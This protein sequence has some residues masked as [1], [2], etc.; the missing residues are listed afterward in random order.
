MLSLERV[1][2]PLRLPFRHGPEEADSTRDAE[3][4]AAVR[5]KD[6]GRPGCGTRPS[7]I[8][9]D[10]AHPDPT[11][12]PC[13]VLAVPALETSLAFLEQLSPLKA[14]VS[15]PAFRYDSTMASP[16]PGRPL[17]IAA[18]AFY[19]LH[20]P[21][22]CPRRVFLDASGT[23]RAPTSPYDEVLQKLGARH[24]AK[25][26]AT[27]GPHLDLRSLPPDERV[28]RT[29]AAV[30]AG[31]P[32]IFQPR[33]VVEVEL[34]GAQC[35]V[36]GEPDFLIK[37][38]TG[39]VIRDAKMARRVTEADHPEILRQVETYGWLFEQVVGSPPVALEVFSGKSEVVPIASA[40][41][42]QV[43]TALA[44]L[45]QLM[46]AKAEPYSPVGWTKCGPCPFHDHCWPRAEAEHD[47]AL[48]PKVDQGLAIALRQDGVC[49]REQLLARF[50]DSSLD[51]YQRPWGK[52]MQK[53]GKAATSILR[54]AEAMRDDRYVLI[55]P[56]QLPD[57]QS[58]VVFDLEG[59]PPH[60]DELDKVF[61]WGLQAFGTRPG[62]YQGVVAGFGEAGDQEGWTAFLEASKRVLDEH[63]DIPWLH[64]ASYERTKLSTYISRFGDPDGVASR[65]KANLLDLLPIT[66]ASVILP[67]PSYSL[68]VVEEYVGFKRTQEEYGGTWAMAKFIEAT[69]CEQPAERDRLVA[70]IL[71]YNEEDLKATWAVLEWLRAFT[72][73]AN[74]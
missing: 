66:Q 64:W 47:V 29:V 56:P 60:L 5:T 22:A 63:G 3:I 4:L 65:V 43:L 36:V 46:T 13:G 26:L 45:V 8:D 16:Q 40:A 58:F 15:H 67:L 61:L 74:D 59:L 41:A 33:F 21:S 55:Q 10:V 57:A 73:T 17:R 34:A 53:V 38:G 71:T 14:L 48:I 54:S 42:P 44:E 6:W 28:A 7:S 12:C 62:S 20:S 51:A 25:H 68:K 1:L 30:Q 32:L 37:Q 9:L 52:R 70:E 39:Y 31:E 35:V 27:L 19:T 23:A 11:G 49:S 69:E 72:R 2:G 18:S 24:E 50:D